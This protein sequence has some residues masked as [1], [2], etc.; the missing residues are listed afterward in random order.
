MIKNNKEKEGRERRRK[1]VMIRE[2]R[3]RGRDEERDGERKRKGENYKPGWPVM[4]QRRQSNNLAIPA[5]SVELQ[6]SRT[7]PVVFGHPGFCWAWV[8]SL[9][10]F[11]S[12]V[13]N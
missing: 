11:K 8:T 10:L 12:E 13:L 7:D 2:R 5:P 1:G 4:S 9:I 6:A 3:E